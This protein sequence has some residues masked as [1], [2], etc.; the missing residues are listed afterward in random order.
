[1]T[2][3][4]IMQNYYEKRD[5]KKGKKRSCLGCGVTLSRY[6]PEKQCAVCKSKANKGRSSELLDEIS[7]EWS[8]KE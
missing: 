3:A 1:M 8:S 2:N 4:K 6:N 5:R 7:A